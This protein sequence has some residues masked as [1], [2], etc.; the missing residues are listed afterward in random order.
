MNHKEATEKIATYHPNANFRQLLR[1]DIEF[2][3]AVKVLYYPYEF[4]E[5]FGTPA[6]FLLWLEGTK[7]P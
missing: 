7:K 3:E 5:D 6:E 4:P 2:S 1:T